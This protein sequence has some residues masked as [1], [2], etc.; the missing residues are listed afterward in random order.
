VAAGAAPEG[1][2]GTIDTGAIG[3]VRTEPAAPVVA[4]VPV[5]VPMRPAV[6]PEPPRDAVTVAPWRLS[7]PVDL[8]EG[9]LVGVPEGVWPDWRPAPEVEEAL[10]VPAVEWA[11]RVAVAE[12]LVLAAVR[13]PTAATREEDGVVLAGRTERRVLEAEAPTGAEEVDDDADLEVPEV[14]RVVPVP[15]P[16]PGLAAVPF[17]PGVAVLEEDAAPEGVVVVV[18]AVSVVVGAGVRAVAVGVV[19]GAAAGVVTAG[20]VVDR[21]G[22]CA[23]A[24]AASWVREAM[25]VVLVVVL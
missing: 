25:L 17:L 24:V 7:V 18:G 8:A 16:L 1:A 19:A 2:A 15:V 4:W 22:V 14:L 21:P 10:G 13:P 6:P 3:V 9:V 20:V 5:P 23:V 11:P 12:G